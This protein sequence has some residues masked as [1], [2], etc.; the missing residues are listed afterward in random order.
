M[1]VI[2]VNK[3]ANFT[4]MSNHHLKNRELSLKAKGLMSQMLSLP[5]SWD[6]SVAGLVAI[7]V[8][9]ETAIKNALSEL[10]KKG[11]LVVTKLTPDKT[12]SGRIEY[13]YDL[14][15]EPQLQSG[16]KQGA[17]KQGIENQPLEN[18]P[19][20]N[21]G[22]L[23]TNDKPTKELSTKV[24][25]NKL[26]EILMSVEFIA[27][28]PELHEAFIGFIE[29]RKSVKKPLTERALKL[30]VNEAYSLSGGNIHDMILIVNRSVMNCWQ[31]FYPLKQVDEGKVVHLDTTAQLDNLLKEALELE[32][33]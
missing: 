23:I 6:Y 11:Y 14:Y 30:A 20:E 4:V 13:I 22:Q 25:K 26:D 33:G 2:R 21:V 24:I 3:T 15:E 7:N 18:Q 31:G 28:N 29:M 5:D 32:Q 10:K 8:E 19:L 9:S 16:K 17:E 1:S 12:D 27:N